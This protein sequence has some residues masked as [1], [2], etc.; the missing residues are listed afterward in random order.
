MGSGQPRKGPLGQVPLDS[1]FRPA[2]AEALR[3]LLQRLEAE[4]FGREKTA[5]HFFHILTMPQ[6]SS[7]FASYI[8]LYFH[9]TS[10]CQ[11]CPSGLYG[12]FLCFRER[13]Q[14][15]EVAQIPAIWRSLEKASWLLNDFGDNELV[16]SIMAAAREVLAGRATVAAQLVEQHLLRLQ[17]FRTDPLSTAT[18]LTE[19]SRFREVLADLPPWKEK[20]EIFQRE[21]VAKYELDCAKTLKTVA[22]GA[23]C[24]VW[25]HRLSSSV[26]VEQVIDQHCPGRFASACAATWLQQSL[27]LLPWLLLHLLLPAMKLSKANHQILLKL[28]KALECCDDPEALGQLRDALVNACSLLLRTAW[29]QSTEIDYA[30]AW[31]SK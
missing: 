23:S 22:K 14:V 26:Q 24:E 11:I 18:A 25:A 12:F 13:A 9:N 28:R 15:A 31:L 19:R 29:C 5:P 6:I 30:E 7:T 3:P 20:V 27:P 10:W 4:I 2:L 21:S 8:M 16:E 1:T 17:R